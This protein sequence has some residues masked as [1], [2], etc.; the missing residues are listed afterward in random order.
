M[1]KSIAVIS[2]VLAL[3]VTNSTNA[4]AQQQQVDSLIVLMEGNRDTTGIKRLDPR[5]ALLY[6]AV[7]PGLGQMY[8][9]KYWKLPFVYGG[10]GVTLFVV[11][12][13]QNF[14]KQYRE[15]LYRY[16][17]TGILP[18]G[19]TEDNL[20]YVVDRARRERDYYMI[21]TGVWYILQIVDAHVDA[22]LQEFK[23]NKDL[24]I[25]LNP[26][27]QQNMLTGRT[28]GLTLSFKF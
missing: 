20:R 11:K 6:S 3:V 19:R 25:S 7:F 10:F 5:K 2:L 15:D 24:K 12:Y 22:H 9:G 4:T 27:V 18:V 23:W 26:S 21:I 28:T 1:Y 17:A 13:Y 8:N 14:Y 16:L